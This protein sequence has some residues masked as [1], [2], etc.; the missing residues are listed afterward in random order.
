MELNLGILNQDTPIYRIVDFFDA[1]ALLQ[2]RLL[3]FSRISKFSDENE[4]IDLLLHALLLSQ[5]PC[6]GAIGYSWKTTEDAILH[7]KL[8]QSKFYA[9][10]WTCDPDS[11]AMWTLY[12][13]LKLGV[14]LQTTIGKLASALETHQIEEANRLRNTPIGSIWTGCKQA[15]VTS[16]RY[17]DLAK[18]HKRINRFGRAYSRFIERRLRHGEEAPNFADSGRR[19]ND[20]FADLLGNP[21]PFSVKSAAYQ[22][23][24]E[25]RALFR[26]GSEVITQR[27]AELF[28]RDLRDDWLL[29]CVEGHFYRGIHIH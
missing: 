7:H 3:R 11:I 27:L 22:H 15:S 2:T 20:R 24:Q 21:A 13:S 17:V 4:G 28:D 12:S 9:C 26:A 19:P 14:R 8:T 6:K 25:I 23:E 29:E 5:G 16:V 18:W 10:C 1:M